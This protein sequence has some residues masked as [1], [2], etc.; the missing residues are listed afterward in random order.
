MILFDD[1]IRWTDDEGQD[2]S[3]EYDLVEDSDAD[4]KADVT[5]HPT[6]AGSS[7]SDHIFLHPDNVQISFI[8]S[9]DKLPKGQPFVEVSFQ[10][11]QPPGERSLQPFD[12]KVRESQF[13]PGPGVFV[14]NVVSNA[15]SAV[16]DAIFGATKPAPLSTWQLPA[17][18]TQRVRATSIS[19]YQSVTNVNYI[20]DVY[21]QLLKARKERRAFTVSR[22]GEVYYSLILAGLSMKRTSKDSLGR[23]TLSFEQITVTTPQTASGLQA[24]PKS[25]RQNPTKKKGQ[26]SQQ[27]SISTLRSASEGG[28]PLPPTADPL[29]AKFDEAEGTGAVTGIPGG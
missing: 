12:L 29:P 18:A 10:T 14:A 26:Q 24:K 15:I 17:G 21:N 19:A 16:G 4:H 25:S 23:F 9:N 20:G 2:H 5:Q 11:L 28:F 8:V 6:L 13:T 3:I 1:F 22:L 27:Q 7:I